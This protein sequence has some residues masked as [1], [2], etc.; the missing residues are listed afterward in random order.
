[1]SRYNQASL[2]AAF[3]D[4]GIQ[5]GDILFSHVSL[6]RLGLADEGRTVEI[7]SAVVLGAL[8]AAVGEAGTLLVPTYTYSIGAGELFD[9][10]E[11][12][13]AVG[14]FT[15]IFRKLP[16]VVRSA[17]PML[18]VA[19]QGPRARELLSALPKT[20]Y[21]P[22]SVYERL[23]LSGAKICNIGV[24]LYYATFRH[25]IEEL[26]EVPFRFKKAFKGRVRENGV[27]REEEW[28]YSCAP[29]LDCCAPVG[30]PLEKLCR[31]AG[32]VRAVK[33]GWSEVVC[34]GAREY[35][36]FGYARLKEQPWLTAKGPPCSADELAAGKYNAPV[37]NES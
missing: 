15:E 14:E 10:Q 24:G 37:G 20:S 17:E 30:L 4:C 5:Q 11:T 18:A 25:H 8:R 34:I 29:R 31:E 6:G 27:T 28:I 3:R 19:G 35:F 23:R 21:G 36:D 7:V 2:T 1:M 26:A 16:G 22:G 12:P 33:V 32:L 13:S 9:V